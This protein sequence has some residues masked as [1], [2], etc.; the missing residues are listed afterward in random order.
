MRRLEKGWSQEQLADM[1]GVSTRTVQ[2][3]ER[4]AKAA[5][6][7]LKCLAAVLE[8]DFTELQEIAP[9]HSP[10]PTTPANDAAEQEALEYV[11]DIKA[12]Y[13]HLI[14]FAAVA[15][16]LVVFNLIMTPGYFWAKW[17][18]MGWG[19]GIVLH[20]I[21]TFEVVNILGP[22]WERRAVEKRLNRR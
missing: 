7:T 2:L 13:N 9:M 5:P 11:R 21:N 18:L 14:V 1:A 20:A 8:T 4:G 15:L 17:A 3:L 19:I 6:E 16:G 22:D 10:H 12:F